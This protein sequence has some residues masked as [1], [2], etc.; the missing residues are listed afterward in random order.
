MCVGGQELGVIG[1]GTGRHAGRHRLEI[2]N[3]SKIGRA[4]E[5]FLRERTFL[6]GSKY[7][8]KRGMDKPLSTP[9][10]L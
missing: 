8:G 1:E 10:V 5:K 9:S 2:I 6:E 7:G 4:R 3:G